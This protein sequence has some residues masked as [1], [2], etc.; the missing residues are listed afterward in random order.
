MET[1]SRVKTSHSRVKRITPRKSSRQT[2]LVLDLISFCL[3]IALLFLRFGR[4]VQAPVSTLSK[5]LPIILLFTSLPRALDTG[6]PELLRSLSQ[7]LI[8]FV[9]GVYVLAVLMGAPLTTHI[10]QTVLLSAHIAIMASLR[11][12]DRFGNNRL[13]W[14]RIIT[15]SRYLDQTTSNSKKDRNHIARHE[16]VIFWGT[17]AGA[18]L[19][20]IP[21]PLDWDRD[22]QVWPV[23]VYVGACLGYAVG[24]IAHLLLSQFYVPASIQSSAKDKYK[25]VEKIR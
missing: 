4:L 5:H 13:D 22:W 21:I 12:L 7:L 14:L 24:G 15:L 1:T 16:G 17:L 11:T 9:P 18:Y 2:I 19:G 3:P 10:P 25:K 8:F 20:A 6:L 23:T